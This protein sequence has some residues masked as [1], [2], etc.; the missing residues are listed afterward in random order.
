[1]TEKEK[2][3]AIALINKKCEEMKKMVD[4]IYKIA[5]ELKD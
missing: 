4:E 1:M 2:K 3:E 5:G